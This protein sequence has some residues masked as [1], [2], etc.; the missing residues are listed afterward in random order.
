MSSR[1]LQATPNHPMMTAAGKKPIGQ[2][3]EGEQIICQDENTHTCQ[4]FTVYNKTET[5]GGV[6]PVY[7]M[8]VDG[9]STFMM[10]GVMVLQK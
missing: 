6:Q 8:V 1:V 9:G 3:S 4:S 7:N 10:N 5:A 2:I